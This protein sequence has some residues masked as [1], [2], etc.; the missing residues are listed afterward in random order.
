MGKWKS[1]AD[2]RREYGDLSLTRYALD[3]T[4]FSLFN[5]WLNDAIRESKYDPTAMILSTVDSNGFPDARVVLLKGIEDKKFIFYTNYE[6][7]KGVQISNNPKVALTFYWPEFA[8]QVRVSGICKRISQSESDDYFSKR[9][10]D[11]QISAIASPQSKTLETRS[12]L[13]ETIN[14]LIKKYQTAPIVRP[15]NWGGYAVTPQKIEFWVGRANR[16]HD[17]F[18]YTLKSGNWDIVRLAP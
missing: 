4:P 7:A 2:V 6:S 12:L 14:N 17:R 8:R 1:I 10:R 3:A 18:C 5:T 13:E 16:L 11:S 9:P 15:E